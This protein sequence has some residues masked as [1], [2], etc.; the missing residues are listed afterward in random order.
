MSFSRQKVRVF[1]AAATLGAIFSTLPAHAVS[2]VVQ[3]FTGEPFSKTKSLVPS[4]LPSLKKNVKKAVK[5][6]VKDV[7]VDAL[8]NVYGDTSLQKTVADVTGNLGKMVVEG[9]ITNTQ[10]EGVLQNVFGTA[11]TDTGTF[12]TG[13]M[14]KYNLQNVAATLLKDPKNAKAIGAAVQAEVE[15][16]AKDELNKLANQAIASVFP[17][18]Q[19]VQFDLTNLNR[20]TLKATLRSAI[21]NAL[22]QSYL[23]PQYVAVYM[24]VSIVCPPC[25]EK[26]HG[27]LRRFDKNY[28]RPL[29]ESVD[30]EWNRFAD[31]VSAESARVGQQISAE[32]KRLKDRVSAEF[33]RQKEDVQATVKSAKEKFNAELERAKQSKVGVEIDRELNDVQNEAAREFD[34]AR[35]E[36]E[37]EYR[38]V[39]AEAKRV[40]Q[41]VGAEIQREMND[42][43]AFMKKVGNAAKDELKREVKKVSSQAKAVKDTIQAELKRVQEQA[44]AALN[45][46]GCQGQKAID[47]L[48]G[49]KKKKKC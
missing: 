2:S 10:V 3:P 38:D 24:A 21:V 39:G 18:L 48:R 30:A 8:M 14:Q 5:N 25:M 28:I 42:H 49:K 44:Q 29:T 23:G 22:A 45:K 47:K 20:D 11:A 9:S 15:Q 7:A 17:I 4:V 46:A 34:Q 40:S 12:A 37:R 32:L 43:L 1:I 33:T 36:L 26:V 13:L 27:E 35:A 19:G 41:R 6:A 16:Y 31:R